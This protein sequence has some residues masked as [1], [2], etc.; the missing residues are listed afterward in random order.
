MCI[1]LRLIII[2]IFVFDKIIVFEKNKLIK[3]CII[4]IIFFKCNLINI[5]FILSKL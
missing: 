4:D 5:L 1:I 3:I 2:D